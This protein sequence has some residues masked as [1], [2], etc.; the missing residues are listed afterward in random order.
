[1]SGDKDIARFKK[2]AKSFVKSVAGH[3]PGLGR[4]LGIQDTYQKSRKL[5]RSTPKAANTIKRRVKTNIRQRVK[6]VTRKR[7]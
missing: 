6:K 5:A 4:V 3:I 1:M 7:W 2:E